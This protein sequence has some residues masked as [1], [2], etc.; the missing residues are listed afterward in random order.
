VNGECY[1]SDLSHK[2]IKSE[3]YAHVI[4]F[5]AVN[6][7]YEPFGGQVEGVLKMSC[8]V[9]LTGR[10]RRGYM[11]ATELYFESPDG[12]KEGFE[13]R[14]EFDDFS[15]EDTYIFLPIVNILRSDRRGR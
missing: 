12:S 11:M 8:S 3:L 1:P 15:E 2:G 9:M 6:I 5:Y 7:G 14:N 4:A 13:L 10:R